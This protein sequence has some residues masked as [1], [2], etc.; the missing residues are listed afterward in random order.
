MVHARARAAGSANARKARE[1]GIVG[2]VACGWR[3]PG[4]CETRRQTSQKTEATFHQESAP[5]Y[6]FGSSDWSRARSFA[7]VIDKTT[8]R[9]SFVTLLQT[10]KYVPRLPCLWTTIVL[11]DVLTVALGVHVVV[12]LTRTPLVNE[13]STP[14]RLLMRRWKTSKLTDVSMKIQLQTMRK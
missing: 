7:K 12:V 10:N 14:R 2:I 4:F 1:R 3:V 6:L 8:V 13:E 5:R 9:S 11:R